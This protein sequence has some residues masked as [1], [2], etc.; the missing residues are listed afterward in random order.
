MDR[1]DIL[2]AITDSC[3]NKVAGSQLD[4]VSVILPLELKLIRGSSRNEHLFRDQ[5]SY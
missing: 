4:S 5:T 3:R 1:G 2:N